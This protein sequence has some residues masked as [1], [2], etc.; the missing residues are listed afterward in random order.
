MGIQ[1]ARTVV[2]FVMTLC[3]IGIVCSAVLLVSK[4]P[5]GYGIDI[6]RYYRAMMVGCGV[7]FALLCA[8]KHFLL[9]PEQ[10]QNS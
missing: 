1:R 5:I 3:L 6:G 7:T 2:E 8:G 4:E 10:K 9:R